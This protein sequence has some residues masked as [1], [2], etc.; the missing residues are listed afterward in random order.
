MVTANLSSLAKVADHETLKL[1]MK[2]AVWPLI[3]M[4]V[5]EGFLDPVKDKEPQTSEQ[6]LAEK[7]KKTILP[8]HK[9]CMF[10]TWTK[11]W[12]NKDLGCGS[13][14]QAQKEVFFD[15]YGKRSMWALPSQSKTAFQGPDGS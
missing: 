11:E 14:A 6:E 4:N 2:S 1:V 10:Q 9:S 13:V 15:G 7:V 8:R 12:A 3:Q 5:P